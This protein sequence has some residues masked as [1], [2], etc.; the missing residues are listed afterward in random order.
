MDVNSEIRREEFMRS[1][2]H[3]DADM[4]GMMEYLI[5]QNPELAQ[6]IKES[7]DDAKEIF[8][9]LIGESFFALC[10]VIRSF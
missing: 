2:A 10:S 8:I 3:D 6:Q 4:R 9:H 1:L 5:Y 7:P